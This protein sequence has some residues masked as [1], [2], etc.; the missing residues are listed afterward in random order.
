MFANSTSSPGGRLALISSMLNS[1]SGKWSPRTTNADIAVWPCRSATALVIASP[2]SRTN[3]TASVSEIDLVATRAVYS[4]REWP[5]AK[6]QAFATSNPNSCSSTLRIAIEV[7]R[8]AGWAF[9]VSFSLDCFN[10]GGSVV[11]LCFHANPRKHRPDLLSF[12][13]QLDKISAQCLVS[14]VKNLL[15]RLRIP[16]VQVFSHSNILRALAWEKYSRVR[17]FY[18]SSTL[19]IEKPI[20]TSMFSFRA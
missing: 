5:K 14:F 16:I 4:P 20:Q 6:V 17:L 12:K 9:S 2:R 18:S 13:Y 19:W 7:V 8:I 15:C 11:M 1:S 10:R 3:L